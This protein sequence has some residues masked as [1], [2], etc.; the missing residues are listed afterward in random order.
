MTPLPHTSPDRSEHPAAPTAN[1]RN[2]S[3]HIF[4]VSAGLVGACLTVIGLFNVLNYAGEIR[5]K[6]DN[7]LAIDAAA[8]LAACFFAYLALRTRD[9]RRWQRLERVADA[10]FLVGLS[11]MVAIGALIAFEFI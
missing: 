6:A 11:G 4:S 2:L 7:L 9:E 3:G 1:E 10:C 5:G 8:F